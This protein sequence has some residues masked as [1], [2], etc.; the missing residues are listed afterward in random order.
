MPNGGGFAIFSR[1]GS[2][3]SALIHLKSHENLDKH[4][5][6]EAKN[7]IYWL[8]FARFS[9]HTNIFASLP[10][11]LTGTKQVLSYLQVVNSGV[12]AAR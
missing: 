5:F 1:D 11:P 2:D 4:R 9:D 6:S 7:V 3:D 8:I 12:L 10:C